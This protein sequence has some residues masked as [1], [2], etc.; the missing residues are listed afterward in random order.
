MIEL[1]GKNEYAGKVGAY[2]GAMYVA[3]GLYRPGVDCLMFEMTE[4]RFCPVCSRAIE[5]II[6]LY[7]R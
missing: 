7:T 4:A 1:L 2:E 5:R 6:D 3:K